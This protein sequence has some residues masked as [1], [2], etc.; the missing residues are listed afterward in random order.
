MVEHIKKSCINDW[1]DTNIYDEDQLFEEE[2]KQLDDPLDIGKILVN[3]FKKNKCSI[4]THNDCYQ[5]SLLNKRLNNIE[6]LNNNAHVLDYIYKNR[7][8]DIWVRVNDL[9]KSLKCNPNEI[10]KT[11]TTV[12]ATTISNETFS[13]DDYLHV[14]NVSKFLSKTNYNP[15][16][17]KLIDKTISFQKSIMERAILDLVS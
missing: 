16:L 11:K 17:Y 2:I 7:V 1:L 14:S 12:K 8:H 4:I 9:A 15:K 10:T 3:Y 13:E 6:K 5:H